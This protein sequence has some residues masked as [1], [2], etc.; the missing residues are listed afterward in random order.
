MTTR[1]LRKKCGMMHTIFDCR[2]TNLI[3]KVV[4]LLLSVSASLAY[5]AL[6]HSQDAHENVPTDEEQGEVRDGELRGMSSRESKTGF[7]TSRPA[8]GGP[9]SPE[10]DLEESDREKEPAFR[11]PKIDEAFQPWTDWK[12]RQNS[13]NG[14]QLSAHYSTLFQGLSDAVPGGNDR[15]S[16]GVLRATMK[17]TPIGRDTADTGSLV[18]TLDHRHGFRDTAPA[19]LAGQAGYIGITGLFYNDIGFAVINL[20]WQQAFNDGRTGLIVGRYDPNDYMNVLGYVNPWTIFSNLAINLDASVALPDSSW[21]IGAGHWLND[22]WYVLGGI[23]D[24]NGLGSDNLEFFEGGAEFFKYAHLGWSPTKSDRYFKNVHVLAWHVDERE[25]AGIPSSH[26]MAVA[27]NWTFDDRWMPFARLGWSK[28]SAPIYNQSA[29]LGLIRKF[30]YRSDLVGA[31][32]NHGDLPDNS[33]GSQTTIEGF[34]RFQFSQNLA[35][36]P[37]LQVLLDPALNPTDDTVWVY[38]LRVRLSF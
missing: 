27:A 32:I 6:S 28:G 18:V 1:V 33:L 10:G 16:G 31:A 29:T 25:D 7:A 17:W 9:T 13:E 8:F 34:W 35:I 19:G 22:Q 38:G 11:F 23:N 30:M 36:T 2:R 20:N 4:G 12:T 26:G 24:A 21:G 14:F 37:S 3:L 15:A 5:P